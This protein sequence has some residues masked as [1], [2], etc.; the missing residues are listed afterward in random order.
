MIV[1]ATD[2]VAVAELARR[3]ER[4][5]VEPRDVAE[6]E[7]PRGSG[8]LYGTSLPLPELRVFGMACSCLQNRSVVGLWDVVVVVAAT[9][10]EFSISDGTAKV[11]RSTTRPAFDAERALS[12]L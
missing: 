7:G 9:E 12:R 6:D 8:E 5:E 11:R 10:A 3:V 2:A 1:A 4:E